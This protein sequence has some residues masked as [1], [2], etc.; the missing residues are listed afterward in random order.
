MMPTLVKDD[1]VR[2]GTIRP[3]LIMAC[4]GWH[5]SQWVKVVR[6]SFMARANWVLINKPNLARAVDAHAQMLILS[7]RNFGVFIT[8]IAHISASARWIFFIF[9]VI[10]RINW[11]HT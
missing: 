3:M 5:G 4:Y 7:C 2:S 11:L 10:T 9:S 1:D 8:L 6:N